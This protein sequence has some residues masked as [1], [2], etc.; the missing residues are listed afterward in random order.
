MTESNSNRAAPGAWRLYRVFCFAM[1]GI[2]LIVTVLAFALPTWGPTWFPDSNPS[3]WVGFSSLLV[4]LGLFLTVANAVMPFLP[5]NA[6]TY[7]LHVTN[8][9]LSAAGIFFAPICVPLLLRFNTP[10]VRHFFGLVEA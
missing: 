5:R 9:V 1:V 6:T 10:E 3:M 7:G 2:N 8:L 4:G